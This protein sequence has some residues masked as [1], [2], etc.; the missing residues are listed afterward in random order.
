MAELVPTALEALLD[1]LERGTVEERIRA[2]SEVLDRGGVPRSSQ[3]D[4]QLS[5]RAHHS[6]TPAGRCCV[7][8][9]GCACSDW[10]RALG[11]T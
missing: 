1:A 6:A 5:G 2:A 4:L 7:V 11:I 8:A 3:V 10:Q 9:T